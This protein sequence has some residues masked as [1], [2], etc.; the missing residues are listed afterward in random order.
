MK[1][2]SQTE[3]NEEAGIVDKGTP[4]KHQ[5]WLFDFHSVL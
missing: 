2:R 4:E 3:D 1:E 5:K